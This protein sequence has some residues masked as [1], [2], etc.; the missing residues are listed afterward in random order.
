MFDGG[1]FPAS[2]GLDVPTLSFVAVCVAALLGLFLTF[3]WFQ[4][5]SVRALAW[6]GSAYLIGASSMALWS[7][8]AP[9]YRLPPEIPGALIFIACGMIWNGVRLFHERRL[10][11]LASVAGAIL[12]LAAAQLPWFPDGGTARIGLGALVVAAYTFCIAYE[13]GRERRKSFYSRTAAI[14][15]PM[16]HAGIFLLP[17][18]MRAFLPEVIAERWL[19]V[20]ALEVIIYAVGTAFIVLTMVTDRHVHIYR[21]AATRDHLTGL[22]NRRAFYEGAANLCA[23]QAARQQPVSLLMFDLD[24]FKSI[25]DRFGHAVGDVALQEFAAVA[26]ASLR[27]NDIVARF[28]GEEFAA[29]VPADLDVACRIADRLRIGFEKAGVTI[30]GHDMGA[31]VSIGAA[32]SLEPVVDLD[33]LIARADAALYRAKHEGR[34]RVFRAQDEPVSQATPQIAGV[35]QPPDAERPAP[36]AQR[37]DAA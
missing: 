26:R 12:W 11:P 4:Q 36:T 8:P 15:V 32:A 3:A 23:H 16:L 28:G 10:L 25:N 21:T 5:R 37:Q 13:L 19:T 20:F 17:L 29:I 6:W 34:N 1:I 30:A 2:G 35:R 18:V 33:A 7:A 9:L 31:T 24:H 22:L 14:V 27:A